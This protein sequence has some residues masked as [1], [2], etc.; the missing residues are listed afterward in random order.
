MSP[1]VII[2]TLFEFIQIQLRAIESPE[3]EYRLVLH[4]TKSHVPSKEVLIPHSILSKLGEVS[5][6]ALEANL[7]ALTRHID[8]YIDV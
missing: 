6:N 1:I 5:L 2:G 8:G 4:R 7:N 3:C